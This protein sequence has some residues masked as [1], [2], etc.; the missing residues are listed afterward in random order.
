MGKDPS[1]FMTLT[2][3]ISEIK[4]VTYAALS[5]LINFPQVSVFFP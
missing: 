3:D 4:E 2:L 5:S 1:V